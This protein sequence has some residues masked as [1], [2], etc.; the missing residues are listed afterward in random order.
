MAGGSAGDEHPAVGS[1]TNATTDGGAEDGPPLRD[2]EKWVDNLFVYPF[3]GRLTLVSDPRGVLVRGVGTGLW[4]SGE[5]LADYFLGHP[6]LSQGA[7]CLELGAGIGAVGLTIAS[8]GARFVMLT[9][10]ERQLPLIRK[11]VE[12]NFPGSEVRVEAQALDW[13]VAE[14]RAGLAPWRGSWTLI[15]A[16]DVGYD[17][18]MFEPFVQTLLAQAS[19]STSIYLALPDRQ[20]EEEPNVADF[21]EATRGYFDCQVV[22]K[23][24]IESFQ[25]VTHVLLLTRKPD[26]AMTE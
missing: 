14:Q 5:V 4:S 9:D 11:N 13:Q 12:T 15:V 7:T 10:I 3:R 18:D 24:Q 17:P 1:G 23:R 8:S 22:H 2:G 6:E 19:E 20:E 21:V 16:S 26:V 25:S